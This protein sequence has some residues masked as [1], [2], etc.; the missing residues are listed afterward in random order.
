V[1]PQTLTFLSRSGV[2]LTPLVTSTYDLSAA[3]QAIDAVLTDPTQVKIH[4]TST[5]TL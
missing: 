2:D 3:D 4:V 5:A 1:W